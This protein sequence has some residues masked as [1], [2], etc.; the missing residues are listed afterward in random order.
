MLKLV[1]DDYEFGTFDYGAKTLRNFKIYTDAEAAF[2][3]TGYTATIKIS[4]DGIQRI[5]DIDGTF[6][7]IASGL[8]H[9]QLE[10]DKM[11][12]TSGIYELEVEL[13]KEGEVV[14][15][16][17]VDVYVFRSAD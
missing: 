14:S 7:T 11:F 3:A 2:N 17:T 6:D 12:A 9:F 5:S 8:G 10:S 1:L 15:T 4:K 13:T 16:R